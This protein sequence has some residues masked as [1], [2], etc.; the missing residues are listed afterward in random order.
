V[1]TSFEF[2]GR[3]LGTDVMAGLVLYP[4]A[5][6]VEVIERFREVSRAAPPELVCLA[7]LRNAPPAP[8]VPPEWHGKPVAGLAAC[9]SG[10]VE[11]A[12]DV[13]APLRTLGGAIG[14]NF[15]RKPFA[16]FQTM[17]DAGEPVGRR[18]YW[19]SG[20]FDD[21]CDAA[22]GELAGHA[23]PMPSAFCG[24]LLMHLGTPPGDVRPET[25]AIPNRSRYVVA[26]KSSWDDP[27]ADDGMV[28][29]A[30][31][32]WQTM[33]R[34]ANG[35][36]YVNFFNADEGREQVRAAY[37]ADALAR[38]G[39]LKTRFDPGNLFSMNHPVRPT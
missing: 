25:T 23:Q 3:P 28:R 39:E 6:A 18:Y 26:I 2:Q 30:R 10:P 16:A 9:Y 24:V 11:D 32:Y 31:E 20:Y 37:A 36:A 1:V 5:R 14:D 7:V 22:I 38:L 35:T 17:F 15:G 8:F 21:V 13:V 29:W 19:K 33:S 12:G 34:H 27:A 4:M